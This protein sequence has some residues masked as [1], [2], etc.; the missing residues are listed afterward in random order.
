MARNNDIFQVLVTSGNQP[1]ITNDLKVTQLLPGQIGFFN[2]DTNRSTAVATKNFYIAV[3]LDTDGDG[4]TDDV[5]KS[6]GFHIQ[7]RNLVHYSFRPHTPARSMKMVLRD[8]TADCETEY[9]LKIELRNSEIYRTQGYNQFTKTYSIVTACCD[10][11]EPTCPSGD[12]NEITKL[13]MININNDPTG[14]IKAKAIARQPLTRL[15]HGISV[16]IAKG[17]EVSPEDLQALM[18][19]NADQ[20]DVADYVYTDLEIE[21][22]AQP[23][24]NAAGLN[25]NYFKVRGTVV[26][27]SKIEGFKCN[28]TLDVTQQIAFEEGSGYDVRELEYFASGWK[29][30]P[31][32]LSTINGVANERFVTANAATKYDQIALTHDQYSQG[33]WLEYF[34]NQATL[35]AI[36]AT[37]TVTR[38][39]FMTRLDLFTTSEGFEALADDAAAANVNPTVVERTENAATTNLDGLGG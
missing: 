7:K 3:G 23:V 10:K 28:G 39:A 35:V 30:G 2:S 26:L 38:N 29:Q 37:D 12:A 32:R 9:G 5:A 33:A 6:T 4:V 1:L 17:A 31:Y 8:Y 15:T 27:A 20:T 14:L 21:T 24:N 25:L 22:V 34:S 18:T 13:L 16:D 19:Y 36:P 11:C